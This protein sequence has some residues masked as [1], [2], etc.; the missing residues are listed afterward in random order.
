ML[1]DLSADGVRAYAKQIST[2]SLGDHSYIVVVGED[3]VAIDIQRDLD[4]FD[5][6]LSGI[7]A[8]LVA[9]FET[10]L[11]TRMVSFL[12]LI[13]RISRQLQGTRRRSSSMRRSSCTA[14]V[15]TER[16]SPQVS[17]RLPEAP[18]SW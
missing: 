10:Q 7:D 13:W 16:G 6:V 5:D 4:R 17:L 2:E 15:A 3:A 18:R 1:L 9:V 11:N 12:E 14:P 8:A